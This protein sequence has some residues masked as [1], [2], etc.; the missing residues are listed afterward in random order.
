MSKT[1]LGEA[2]K[3]YCWQNDITTRDL[4][5]DWD[6]SHTTVARFMQGKPIAQGTFLIALQWLTQTIEDKD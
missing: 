1:I 2:L 3:Q 5:A 6:C 4:A